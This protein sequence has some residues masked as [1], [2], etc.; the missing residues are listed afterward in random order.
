MFTTYAGKQMLCIAVFA[1]LGAASGAACAQSNEY[2]QGYDQGYRDGVE[3]QSRMGHR[4]GP[5]GRIIIEEAS[6]GSREGGFC[7]PRDVIQQAIGWRRHI[8][9]TVSNDLCGD[10]APGRVKH[11]DIRYRC[12]DS[13]S[14]RAEAPEN[15][16]LPISCRE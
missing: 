12:G 16:V 13:P 4:D 10:P 9:V 14:V 8:D 5:V 15:S 2:R 1:A 3:A 11:L 6:Y 7:Q